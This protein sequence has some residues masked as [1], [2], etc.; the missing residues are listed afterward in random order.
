MSAGT[1]IKTRPDQN[2]EDLI[3]DG[4]FLEDVEMSAEK[5]KRK[6]EDL[7]SAHDFSKLKVDDCELI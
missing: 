5:N 7:C 4:K 6:L 3:A 2:N 1:S